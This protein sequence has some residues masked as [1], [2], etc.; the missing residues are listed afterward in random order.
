VLSNNF[1]GDVLAFFDQGEQIP[2][3][4][5]VSGNDRQA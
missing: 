2:Y 1:L 3:S 5:D 4:E